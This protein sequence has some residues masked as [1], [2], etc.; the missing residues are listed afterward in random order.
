MSGEG[1]PTITRRLHRRGAGP[2]LKSFARAASLRKR[3]GSSG[4]ADAGQAP[5]TSPQPE[6]A[7]D[8]ALGARKRQSGPRDLKRD[9]RVVAAY[10]EGGVGATF[11]SVGAK[12]DLSAER[13]RQIV[14]RWEKETG[15]RIPRAPERRRIAR[16]Q[17][18]EAR[19]RIAP[20]SLAQRLLAHVRAVPG[21]DCWEWTGPL[22]HPNGRAFGRFEALGEQFANR[23]SFRLWRG[24]IPPGHVVLQAC[25]GRFCINPFHLFTVSRGEAAR[26][27]GRRRGAPAQERCKRGHSLTDD[28]V[29]WN[30]SSTIRNGERVTVRTRLCRICARD[31]HRRNYKK[32]PRSPPLPAAGHEREVELIIRRIE[33][34]KVGDRAAVLRWNLGRSESDPVAV[35]ALEGEGWDEYQARTGSLGSYGDWLASR[36]A[37]HPRVRKALRGL[38]G[39]KGGDD[40]AGAVPRLARSGDH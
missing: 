10:A 30:T 35:P 20:P 3:A 19:K 31:R 4:H 5:D 2:H 23:V 27:W 1:I 32:P 24:E 15:Q 25:G 38:R 14:E 21:S 9:A 8:A 12:L 16:R 34:A 33:R 22:M 7:A 29:T 39:R 11:G 36:I 13:V 6:A 28:N 40:E 26:L 37:D 17:A 18:E